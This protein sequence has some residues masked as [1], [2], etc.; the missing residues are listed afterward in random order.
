MNP[1]PNVRGPLSGLVRRT[2]APAFAA[3]VQGCGQRIG[4]LWSETLRYR[5]NRGYEYEV[6]QVRKAAEWLLVHSDDL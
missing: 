2:R 5:K 4:Q 1:A 6:R 3:Q